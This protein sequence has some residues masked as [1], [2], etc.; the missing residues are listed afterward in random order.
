MKRV[1]FLC[2][3]NYYRSRFAEE[4]F[5]HLAEQKKLDWRADS[6]G[7]AV[8]TGIKNVG[9]I[10][11]DT[12]A[13]LLR[14]QVIPKHAERSPRQVT[15]EELKAADLVFAV[16]EAEHRPLL[17]SRYAGWEDRVTYWHVHDLD[18]YGVA[19]ALAELTSHVQEL[20]ESLRTAPDAVGS[21]AKE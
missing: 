13:G 12:I 20:I 10:S 16:K 21:D 6:S 1:L 18:G 15:H 5:N 14:M 17:A 3:G 7:L 19:E 2:T 8:E 11:H 4:L 9:P